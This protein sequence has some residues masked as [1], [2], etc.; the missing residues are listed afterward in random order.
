[1]VLWRPLRRLP[2]TG[3]HAR[4]KRFLIYEIDLFAV[5]AS[6]YWLNRTLLM[7]ENCFKRLKRKAILRPG[8]TIAV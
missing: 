8:C 1:M 7:S 4:M 2:N 3:Q 5:E 6:T